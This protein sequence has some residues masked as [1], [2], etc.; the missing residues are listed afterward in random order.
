MFYT[1]TYASIFRA[2]GHD[3]VKTQVASVG[4]DFVT[5]TSVGFLGFVL[6]RQLFG[7]TAEKI[8]AQHEVDAK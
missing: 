5:M 1:S 8:K 6:A 4:R 7:R 2:E 3:I